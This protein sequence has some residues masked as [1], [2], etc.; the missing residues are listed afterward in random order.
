M[1]F[2]NIKAGKYAPKL[3]VRNGLLTLLL[4]SNCFV[5]KL[6][7]QT[8]TLDHS[9]SFAPAWAPGNTSGTATAIGGS[10]I[11]CTL[12]FTTSGGVYFGPNETGS[13][14]TPTVTT[15]VYTVG[16]SSNNIELCMNYT[17][18]TQFNDILYQ[19]SGLI[20]NVTFNVADIDKPDAVSNSHYDQV[21]ITG[22]DGTSTFNPTITKYVSG[23]TYVTIS[24]NTASANTTSGQGGNSASNA[25]DQNGTVIVD[26][27]ITPITSVT[28][29]Y[30]NAAGA[31]SNPT[32]Q[33]I[34]IGNISFQKVGSLPVLLSAFSIARNGVDAQLNWT[35]EDEIA[36][37][38]FIIERSSDGIHFN[39]IGEVNAIS[40]SGR[41]KYSYVDVGSAAGNVNILYYRLRMMDKDG[42]FTMSPIAWIKL[43]GSLKMA[44]SVTP[45]PSTDR[46]IAHVSSDLNGQAELRCFNASGQCVYTKHASLVKGENLVDMAGARNLVAGWYVLR[47]TVGD[48]S[49][50]APFTVAR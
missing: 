33:S 29:R 20:K 21:V 49:L 23:S 3:G 43:N 4:L 35:T 5:G 38:G 18:N 37:R 11:N 14:S 10:T 22:S 17:S 39:Q 12:S 27:G 13:G 15:S 40:G 6:A 30:Q 42:S 7:A 19:F 34:S 9:S 50:T 31:A 44:L 48:R 25:G 32:P 41:K 26:F 1:N 47:L 8:F 16:G 46:V 24:G 45:N 2:T 28:I 36:F